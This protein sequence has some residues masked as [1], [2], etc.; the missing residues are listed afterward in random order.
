MKKTVNNIPLEEW[1]ELKD[2]QNILE[3]K[4]KEKQ[5]IIDGFKKQVEELIEGKVKAQ[6]TIQENFDS[7]RIFYTGKVDRSDY[8][9][10]MFTKYIDLKD[11]ADRKAEFY[12]KELSE[13]KRNMKDII[14]ERS[15]K[16]ME[17]D[18]IIIRLKSRGFWKRVFNKD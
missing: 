1:E 6:F 3:E 14:N 11:G 4:L 8:L 10:N 2:I 16:I 7:T 17:L 13:Y 18:S 5:E 9:L 15:S 12:E